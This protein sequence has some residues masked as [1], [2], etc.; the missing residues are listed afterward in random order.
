MGQKYPRNRKKPKLAP[1]EKRVAP[2][3]WEELAASPRD[4]EAYTL[5]AQELAR[6]QAEAE[7]RATRMGRGTTPAELLD[8][9][10]AVSILDEHPALYRYVRASAQRDHREALIAGTQHAV[11]PSS[12]LLRGSPT[13]S[14]PQA[15]SQLG[16]A[17]AGTRQSPVS[18]PNA[19]QLRTFA[20]A[21]EWVRSAI[22]V[23]RDQVSHAEIAILPQEEEEPYSKQVQAQALT[24]LDQPNE[25][26]QNWTELIASAVEDI[27]VLDRGVLSKSMTLGTRQPTGLYA[28]DGATIAIYPAWSG[29]PEEPRY[30]FT[31]PG[32]DRRVPLRNDEAIVLMANPA[33]HRFGLSPIQVLWETIKADL[34]ATQLAMQLVEQKPPPH[35]IQIPGYSQTQLA[36]LAEEYLRNYAGRKEIFFIGGQEDAHVFPL[37]FSAK[38]NQF[39]EWQTW[40]ARKICALLRI[41]PQQVGIT[42]DINKSTGD[43]QQTISEDTG[44][45]PL[46]LLIEIY[47]NREFLAD[48]APTR[49]DGR[50]DMAALNLRACFPAISESA[51]MLHA[52]ETLAITNESLATLPSMTI[53]QALAMRGESPVPG[54][55]TFYMPSQSGAI[56][57]LS[58]NGELGDFVKDPTAPSPAL[59]AQDA[60]GGPEA[61]QPDGVGAAPDDDAARS[62]AATPQADEKPAQKEPVKAVRR[63]FPI[64]KNYRGSR[65]H[66]PPGVAWRPAHHRPAA[67]FTRAATPTGRKPLP[68]KDPPGVLQ[69]RADLG[70]LLDDLFGEV[71]RA[72][73][74]AL[75][76]LEVSE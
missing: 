21:N 37:V 54:G 44:L 74:E 36:G 38:D 43:T 26:R 34:K 17:W 53:N 66:R 58:Y 50:S 22:N 63:D 71:E 47:L 52:R 65:E 59:G 31:E 19:R 29:K 70:A 64:V 32:T 16:Y 62:T 75:R 49:R 76:R 20:D 8:V 6:A 25:Y 1:S 18:V 41:S 55:D 72:G 12:L 61:E 7:Q 45:I 11:A 40:L 28:E 48:F 3:D 23:R 56:P 67:P 30:L 51:R 35:M 14:A 24:I 73:A 69:A 27:L 4:R 15:E 60:A 2:A 5:F 57:W 33:S 68:Y 39:L 42:F 13:G 10:R 46:L 9:R